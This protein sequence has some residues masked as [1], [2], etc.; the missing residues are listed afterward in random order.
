[1]ANINPVYY[2]G[3][4]SGA[5]APLSAGTVSDV[6]QELC[7]QNVTTIAPP[8]PVWSTL[9]GKTVVL[10]DAVVLGGPFGLNG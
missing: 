8:H 1:M 7:D 9:G 10:L 3:D 5:F 4:I 6:C 2:Y